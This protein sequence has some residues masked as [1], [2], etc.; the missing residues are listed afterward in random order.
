MTTENLIQAGQIQRAHLPPR[1]GNGKGARLTLPLI[2]EDYPAKTATMWNAAYAAFGMDA[3]N[4]MVVARP[5]NVS[6]ILD[7]LRADPRY[8]GGGAGVGFKEAVVAQLDSVTPEARAIGAVNIIKKEGGMLVGD[9]TDG[10]G[11]AMSLAP[12]FSAQGETLSGKNILMLGAGGSG[13]AIAF[14]LARR[15]AHLTIA[16]RTAPKAIELAESINRSFETAQAE[17]TGRDRIAEIL[18]SQDA[19]VSVIDDAHSPLDA[20]STLGPMELPITQESIAENRASTEA[21]LKHAK[22]GIIISDIRIR[23]HLVPMLAQAQALGFPTLDGIGM[24]INQGVAAFWWLYG[25]Q[26][27]TRGKEISD[28]QRVMDAAARA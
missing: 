10:E 20:Y 4:M 3:E 14:A 17:G 18:P 12:L 27:T 19:V 11:Y 8:E 22:P 16:N 21:L 15:G 23:A 6:L 7:T 26:L 9:N 13:R 25:D 2:A 24:V 28:V 5:E 1:N